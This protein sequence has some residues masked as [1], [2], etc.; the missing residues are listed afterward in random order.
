MVKENLKQKLQKIVGTLEKGHG[1]DS[2]MQSAIHLFSCFKRSKVSSPVEGRPVASMW[3]L[4]PC[5]HPR[6]FT[7]RLCWAPRD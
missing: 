2:T 7:S 3:Q 5:L 1:G 6:S 4:I